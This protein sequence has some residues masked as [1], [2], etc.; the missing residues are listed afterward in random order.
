MGGRLRGFGA[1]AALCFV[2]ISMAPISALAQDD[3]NRPPPIQCNPEHVAFIETTLG[4]ISAIICDAEARPTAENFIQYAEEGF[5]EGTT[6][7]R[8]IK[9]FVVQG[10][11]YLP[12]GTPKEATRPPIVYEESVIRNYH[13]TLAM[14]HGQDVNS[15]TTQFFFNTAD[16]FQLDRRTG[17]P[18]T[19]FGVIAFDDAA[20]RAVLDKI[21]SVEVQGESGSRCPSGDC[22]ITPIVI[23]DVSIASCSGELECLVKAV[24]ETVL[25]DQSH[26]PRSTPPSAG[27]LS[28]NVGHVYKLLSHDTEFLDRANAYATTASE[29]EDNAQAVRKA[30]EPI[31]AVKPKLQG[32]SAFGVSAWDVVSASPSVSEGFAAL[33]NAHSLASRVETKADAFGAASSSVQ[34]ATARFLAA[35]DETSLAKLRSTY[36]EAIPVYHDVAIE[37]DELAG[38]LDSAAGAIGI[39]EASLRDAARNRFV[40]KFVEPLASG[41]GTAAAFVEGH[42][43]SVHATSSNVQA[44]AQTMEAAMK[45]PSWLTTPVM[46]GGA[47]AAGMLVIA[48]FVVSRRS[49]RRKALAAPALSAV[50]AFPTRHAAPD[51]RD[52]EGFALRVRAGQ[53]PSEV[54]SP[55]GSAPVQP[56]SVIDDPWSSFVSRMETE[57]TTR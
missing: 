36:S 14:A 12:D 18:H 50:A 33:E 31:V 57:Q 11:G 45:D 37:L 19:V 44:D 1:A 56:P 51:A 22:P 43:T 13:Y 46:I 49:R 10:G 3:S 41:L 52:V 8:V 4:R 25:P 55:L 2:T 34:Q 29:I 53:R 54:V 17:N 20:S 42:A 9:S 35:P 21:E 47:A 39:L 7:H 28:R 5:Y 16:N 15:A 30:L 32:Y 40:G 48:A 6:F 38:R 24:A 27:G 26:V 23:E